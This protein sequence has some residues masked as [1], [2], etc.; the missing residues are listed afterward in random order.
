MTRIEKLEM[1]GFKSFPKKTIITF[2]ANFSA[3]AGP[4]GSGMLSRKS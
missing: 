3:I 1:Y 4:N 2:P